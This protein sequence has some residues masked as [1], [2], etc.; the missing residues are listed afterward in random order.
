MDFAIA[1]SEKGK[2]Y[3]VDFWIKVK[4]LYLICKSLFKYLIKIFI[5]SS[6]QNGPQN[7]KQVF[8]LFD[9]VPSSDETSFLTT[10]N[11]LDLFKQCL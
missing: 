1:Y 2:M 4:C 5:L 9:V 11:G 7:G 6:M 10:C 3:F 8:G